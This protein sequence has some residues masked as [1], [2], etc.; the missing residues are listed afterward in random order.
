MTE[1]NSIEERLKDIVT[2]ITHCKAEDLSA[3]TTWESLQAD[4][5]DV[6]QIL[7][8]TEEAFSIEIPDEDAQK[9][10][11][12]GDMVQYITGKTTAAQ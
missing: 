6:V 12:F 8:A 9:L 5:L 3:E 2:R 11:T 7:V 4:S 1:C 10:G